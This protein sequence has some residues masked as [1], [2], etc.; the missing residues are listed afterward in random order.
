MIHYYI[1]PNG[2]ATAYMVV[3]D[4]EDEVRGELWSLQNKGVAQEPDEVSPLSFTFLCSPKKLYKAFVMQFICKRWTNGEECRKYKGSKG[5]FL[6]DAE[7]FAKEK[8]AKMKF[9]DWILTQ[10]SVPEIYTNGT[11]SAEKD[12]GEWS[13]TLTKVLEAA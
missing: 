9:A 4:T 11:I 10:R 1:Q 5:G 13:D 6:P 8:S 2:N 3:G 7:A 12:S